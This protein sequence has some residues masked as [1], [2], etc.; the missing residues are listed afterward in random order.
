M[1]ARLAVE[2]GRFVQQYGCKAHRGL[3]N[4]N[5][6]RYDKKVEKAMRA[7]RPDEL[8]DLLSGDGDETGQPAMECPI[9]IDENH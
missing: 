6:R 1:R 7:L 9:E 2:L 8:S 5:D 4:P 3:L